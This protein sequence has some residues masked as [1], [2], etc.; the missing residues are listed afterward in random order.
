M[1]RLFS[2]RDYFSDMY[3]CLYKYQVIKEKHMKQNDFEEQKKPANP[4]AQ[5]RIT[6]FF[7]TLS[8]R[9]IFNY[10]ILCCVFFKDAC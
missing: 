7:Q 9:H 5:E 2:L 10:L 1:F 3:I 8:F 6:L 4:N